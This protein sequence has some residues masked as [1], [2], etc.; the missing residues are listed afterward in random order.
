[1]LWQKNI[2]NGPFKADNMTM[3][4]ALNSS[5]L[6]HQWLPDEINMKR[7][8]FDKTII[9][10]LKKLRYSIN[11]KDSPVIGKVDGIL[12]LDDKTLEGGADYRGDDTAIGF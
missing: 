2:L 11:E 4:E 8:S 1:M 3:Q 5:R 12:V 6:L 10:T 7:H 9:Q